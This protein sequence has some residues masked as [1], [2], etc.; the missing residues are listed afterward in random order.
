M[1]VAV[2]ALFYLLL[3][4]LCRIY[5]WDLVY[6]KIF[7][8]AVEKLS[9]LASSNVRQCQPGSCRTPNCVYMCAHV[10]VCN[11][12][13]QLLFGPLRSLNIPRTA[14]IDSTVRMLPVPIPPPPPCFSLSLLLGSPPP[15]WSPSVSRFVLTWHCVWCWVRISGVSP[16]LLVRTHPLLGC[17]KFSLPHQELPGLFS[18]TRTNYRKAHLLDFS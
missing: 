5:R 6:L 12:L 1:S 9:H 8:L 17:M 14:L 11:R 10:S 16:G 13:L 2:I 3:V 15:P 7:I 4:G 18:S